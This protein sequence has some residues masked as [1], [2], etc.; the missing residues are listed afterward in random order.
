MCKHV[1]LAQMVASSRNVDVNMERETQAMAI[2]NEA[3]YFHDKVNKQVEILLKSGFV[4]VVNLES[5]TCTCFASSHNITCTCVI[6]AKMV[7]PPLNVPSSDL[8]TRFENETNE[9]MTEES[10]DVLIR[11]KLEEINVFI[12]SEHFKTVSEPKKKKVLLALG[13]AY[14]ICRLESY[15]KK[16]KKRKIQPLFQNRKSKV[17]KIDHDYPL[18][19]K[20]VLNKQRRTVNEDG[21]FKM[22][23]RN[24][25][26]TRKPFQ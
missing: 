4:S 11:R 23:A 12:N 16:T 22:T 18:T 6:V 10:T 7:V 1:H 8:H 24:K 3:Q 5:Y 25:G 13:R 9:Q 17:P 26:C 21:S 15:C 2:F 19:T 20:R 14:N